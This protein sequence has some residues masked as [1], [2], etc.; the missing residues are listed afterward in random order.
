MPTLEYC[1]KTIPCR[2]VGAYWV[3]YLAR[4][5]ESFRMQGRTKTES[6]DKAEIYL[7]QAGYKKVG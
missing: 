6:L 4:S 5:G 7:Q 2:K 1:R 3:A